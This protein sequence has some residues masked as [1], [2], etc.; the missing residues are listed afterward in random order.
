MRDEGLNGGSF[1]FY[2]S[3]LILHL[4]PWVLP[5]GAVRR[6]SATFYRRPDCLRER[7]SV[8]HSPNASPTANPTVCV[9]FAM[10][11]GPIKQI[12]I[13]PIIRNTC[14]GEM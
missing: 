14:V 3:S 9:A 8:P 4:Y 11:I 13:Q 12:S 10:F 6:V 1:M 7:H 5:A 2:R